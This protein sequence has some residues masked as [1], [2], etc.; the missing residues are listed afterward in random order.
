MLIMFIF[1]VVGC[2]MDSSDTL[3]GVAE[4]L[5]PVVFWVFLVP[6]AKS[7]YPWMVPFLSL[8]GLGLWELLFGVVALDTDL[9]L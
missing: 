1:G 2:V 4:V 7:K 6:G 3:D 8:A 5:A 9:P